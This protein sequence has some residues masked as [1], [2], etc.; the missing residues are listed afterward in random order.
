VKVSFNFDDDIIKIY[1][2]EQQ[3]YVITEYGDEKDD[4]QGGRMWSLDV[5]DQDGDK[6]TV[7]LRIEKG[8]NSQLYVDFAN[9]MWVYNVTSIN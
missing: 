4:G 8:G 7:R 6:G 5:I 2:N 9:V 1:S 3:T